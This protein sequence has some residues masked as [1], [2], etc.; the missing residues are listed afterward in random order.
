L[1]T[2]ECYRIG[3]E[4][5]SASLSWRHL[6]DGA[7]EWRVDV[8]LKVLCPLTLLPPGSSIQHSSSFDFS[9]H[10]GLYALQ[11]HS[12]FIL[13]LVFSLFSL[14]PPPLPCWLSH[15]P[16]LTFQIMWI[17]RLFH[18]LSFFSFLCWPKIVSS[19][20]HLSSFYFS[21]H[22]GL[23]LLWWP[24]NCFLHPNHVGVH[25]LCLP[26]LCRLSGSSPYT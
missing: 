21:D 15:C 8:G 18:I 1:R 12:S 19:I 17:Y 4:V 6:E 24:L 9:D 14:L 10:V 3:K 11:L 23:L 7:G 20:H 16:F 2:K 26:F 22:V 25:V 13:L 5:A